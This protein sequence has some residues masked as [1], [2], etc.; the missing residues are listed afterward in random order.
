MSERNTERAL[1][2]VLVIIGAVTIL[3]LLGMWLM[4]TMMMGGG[5]MGSMSGCG[6]F[7]FPLVL[8]AVAVIMLAIVLLRRNRWLI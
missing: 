1:L 8:L 5:M 7:C 6:A 4:H 3:W 2:I